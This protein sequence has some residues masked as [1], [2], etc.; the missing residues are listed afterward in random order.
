MKKSLYFIVV[1]IIAFLPGAKAQE[2]VF[3]PNTDT[4]DIDSPQIPIIKK[5]FVKKDSIPQADAYTW[6]I[7]RRSGER[8]FVD[9]DNSLPGFHRKSLVDG[10]GIAVGYLGNWGSPAQS[11]LF[12]EREEIGL[13]PFLDAF[14]YF[15]KTAEKQLFLNTKIPYSNIYYQTGGSK[16]NSEDRLNTQL[17]SNFGKELN[18]GFDFDY[19]YSRGFYSMLSNKQITYN[20]HANYI[21]DRYQ[22]HAFGRNNYYN[23]SENGGIQND[24]YIT[25]PNAVSGFKGDSQEIPVNL[26]RMWNRL[27]GRQIFV[28]NRYNLGYEKEDDKKEFVPVASFILTTNYKD[29][30]RKFASKDDRVVEQTYTETDLFL[31]YNETSNKVNMYYLKD[32]ANS[33]A[34]DQMAYWSLKNTFAVSLNEGFREWVKFG[35]TA[36]VEQDIRKFAIQKVIRTDVDGTPEMIPMVVEHKNQGSTVIGGMLTKQKGRFLRYNLNADMA[37]LG[38]DIGEFRLEGELSTTIR[39]AGKDASAKLTGYVKNISPK[40]FQNNLRTKYSFWDKDLS[41]TRRVY[42]GGKISIP[43]TGTELSGNVEN[44]QNYIYY[45]RNK[46]IDQE[47]KNIQILSFRADQKLNAGIFHWDNQ[48]VYQ[49]SSEKEII[50]LP[51]LSLY[52]NVYLL[53]KLGVLTV[54]LGVDAQ[55][56]TEYYVPGYDPSLLQFYNQQNTKVGG[57]PLSTAYM[58]LHLKKSRFFI[59][60]YNVAKNIGDPKYFSIPHYPVNPMIMKMGISWD[61]ND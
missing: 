30:Q 22:L 12:F 55:F 42:V 60:M 24:E 33:P 36:F 43:Q 25:N 6:R 44:I 16:I 17:S 11:K 38:D 7:D 13:F 49:M 45:N 35:L 57:F 26:N 3:I 29:Q 46:I 15:H 32:I 4:I 58:N 59:M 18:V 8:I 50:P 54:Q 51:Q 28:S 48:V 40:F 2:P 31:G 23:N 47:S 34:D 10:Q 21:S 56:H 1:L 5:E 9:S 52:S 37:L 61:F 27:K 53:T 41:D 20:F 14:E 19:V 39:F